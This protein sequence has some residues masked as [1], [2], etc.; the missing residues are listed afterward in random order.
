M[1]ASF[2]GFGALMRVLVV[3]CCVALLLS[4]CGGELLTAP[5]AGPRLGVDGRIQ[6]LDKSPGIDAADLD[7]IVVIKGAAAAALYGSHTCSAIWVVTTRP[8][9]GKPR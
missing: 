1:V 3:T 7:S 6:L 5:V 4:A 8:T 9:P 2:C